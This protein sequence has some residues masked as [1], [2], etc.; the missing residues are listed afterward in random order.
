M[1]LPLVLW[2]VTGLLF[3]I[4]PGWSGAYEGL[5]PWRG[6]ALVAGGPVPLAGVLA[7]DGTAAVVR[8]ELGDTALGPLYRMRAADGSSWLVDARS[9]A[10]VSP[11]EREAALAVATDAAGRARASSRYGAVR[12]TREEGDALA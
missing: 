8:A 5:D 4:K 2:T 7:G 3:L 10:R 11:L 12:A 6:G 1:V 9:G